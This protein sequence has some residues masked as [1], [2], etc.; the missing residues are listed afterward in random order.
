MSRAKELLGLIGEGRGGELPKKV[1]D[2]ILKQ[3]RRLFTAVIED[4]LEGVGD[5]DEVYRADVEEKYDIL[6]EGLNVDLSI[7]DALIKEICAVLKKQYGKKV[8]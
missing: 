1:R 6:Y 7:R 4:V 5:S 3:Y 2:F 8:V